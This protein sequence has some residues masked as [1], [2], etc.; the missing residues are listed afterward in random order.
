MKEENTLYFADSQHSWGVER[1]R[2]L[3]MEPSV[4]S[5]DRWD[6]PGD[7]GQRGFVSPSFTAQHDE[8]ASLTRVD[9]KGTERVITSGGDAGTVLGK[10]PG[11][12]LSEKNA[13]KGPGGTPSEKNAGKE[14]GGVLSEKN[15]GKGPGGTPSEKNAGKGP[16]GTPSEKNAGKGP[17]AMPSE[18]VG[19][20]PGGMP[21]E[22]YAGKGPSGKPSE[23]PGK[24]PSGMPS[25]KYAG[26]EP[27]GTPSEKNAGVVEGGGSI[28]D[29]NHPG[30]AAPVREL[31]K[32]N[33]NG[34]PVGADKDRGDTRLLRGAAN[35]AEASGALHSDAAPLAESND[36]GEVV[37]S[38]I[39]I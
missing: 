21:S 37:L 26:K 39:H 22:K 8:E 35:G 15:A 11:G 2:S 12:T 36:G 24:G 7:P 4:Q 27:C 34:K 19:K 33:D 3:T 38:L 17:G 10:E 13:G 32:D 23:N 1:G 29:L 16:G 30:L 5:V 28:P 9:D 6:S 14:P 31:P 18:N 25:E 20:G